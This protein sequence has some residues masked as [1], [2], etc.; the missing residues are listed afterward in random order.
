MKIG[1]RTTNLSQAELLIEAGVWE[2]FINGLSDAEAGML[3]YDWD[4]F[5]RG[6]Q[7]VPPNMGTDYRVWMFRAGRGA[8]KTRS[9]SETLRQMIEVAPRIALIAP[10]AADVRDVLIEG[11]SG[12]MSVFP[13]D[14][15]PFYEPSKRRVTFHNGAMAFAYS[16]EEPE[17]LRGP[18]HHWA[19]GDEPASWPNGEEVL[20]NLLFGLRLGSTPWVMLTGTPKPLP[21]LRALSERPDTYTTTGSTYDNLRALAPGFIADILGRYEGTRLGRQEIYAEFL[22]DTEGALWTEAIIDRARIASFDPSKPWTSLNA[23]L[24]AGGYGALIDRRA[25]RTIVAVDPPGETAECGIVVATAPVQGQ[26]GRDHCVILEDASISGRPEEWGAQ[27]AA[28][29]RRW[30]AERV[31]VESN[32]G[33]DMTRATIQAVDPGLRVEKITAKVGKAARAEPISALYER[34]WVHHAGFLP[35]LEAQMSQWVP[36]VSKSPDRLD[37]LVHAVATLLTEQPTVRS[38]VRSATSRRIGD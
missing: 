7:K 36:G 21:W 14:Q 38:S 19:I 24:T 3:L 17:R 30:N 12:I 35:M 32:Q 6:N 15:R 26:A 2:E 37:A 1:N 10:T 11:D 28:A 23:Y 31:V 29:A 22:D 5:A 34:G 33:G 13:P 9:A 27:V 4:F 20:S 16:A 18:Q 8:G 25:W